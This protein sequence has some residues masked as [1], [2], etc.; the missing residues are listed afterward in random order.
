MR[1]NSTEGV[2]FVFGFGLKGTPYVHVRFKCRIVNVLCWWLG[3][4]TPIFVVT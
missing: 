4:V 1:F 2:T 3:F